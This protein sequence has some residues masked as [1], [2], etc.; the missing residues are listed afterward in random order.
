MYR[1]SPIGDRQLFDALESRQLLAPTITAF[2]AVPGGAINQLDSVSLQVT[3][4]APG[5][6]RAVVFFRDIN[7][8]GR[9]SPGLDI[10]MGAVFSQ[11]A[12]NVFQLNVATD[13]GWDR[14]TPICADAVEFGGAWTV[15][16]P[17]TLSLTVNRQPSVTSVVASP[18]TANAG[19]AITIRGRASD[20]DG[21]ALMRFFLDRNESGAFDNG[22]DT[23]LG[24]VT[25]PNGIGEYVLATNVGL[26]WANS[27]QIV[28]DALDS[29]GAWSLSPTPIFL[30]VDNNIAPVIGTTTQT[31]YRNQAGEPQLRVT[32][33]VSD[34]TLIRAVTFFLDMDLN[35][36]WTPNVDVS[37]ETVLFGGA[38]N[39]NI[40]RTY[41]TDLF[42]RQSV[43]VYVDAMDQGLNW[44][45]A[46]LIGAAIQPA[47]AQVTSLWIEELFT[48]VFEVVADAISPGQYGAAN[49][50]I[51]E[52]QFFIDQNGNRTFDGADRI[53]GGQTA[54][55]TLPNGERRFTATFDLTADPWNRSGTFGAVLTDGSGTVFGT[56]LSSTRFAPVRATLSGIPRINSI[57]TEVG[58]NPGNGTTTF[59]TPGTAVRVTAFWSTASFGGR[60]VTFFFDR[61]NNGLWD[62]AVDFDLGFRFI[63]GTSGMVTFTSAALPA[64]VVGFGSIAA[65]VQDLSGRGADSWGSPRTD[66]IRQIR[67]LPAVSNITAPSSAAANSTV[68]FTAR[69]TDDYGARAGTAFLDIN[70]NGFDSSDRNIT[71]FNR[72]SGTARDGVWQF[73]MN[74]S[75]IAAGT[76]TIYVAA[77]DFY[78][79][80]ASQPGGV[81]NGLW[82][83]RIAFTLTI[84]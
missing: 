60:A 58:I 36:R 75:G 23:L 62:P 35:A 16:G 14:V 2:N 6:V 20:D 26:D 37:L 55:T 39:L 53:L 31:T 79:G 13:S 82:G 5:G 44:R 73:S 25:T 84:V 1:K 15:A 43:P 11:S 46:T 8:N 28:A 45:G 72:I 68:N 3:A 61:N 18:A 10:D 22:T 19:Q 67:G 32:A 21:I 48:D 41:S 70:N 30:T 77:V 63:T 76:Y 51:A 66:S 50:D 59:A 54:F 42:G 7:S 80:H 40:Q 64:S 4:T 71:T 38:S 12:P 74:L 47:A 27:A 69:I 78:R 81:T 29:N 9:W 57:V 49:T 34:I 52:V 33:L 56:Q 83:P 65:A 24:D 17:S